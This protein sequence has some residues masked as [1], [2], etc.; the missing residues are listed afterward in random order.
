MKKIVIA[1]AL[2]L[3][4]VVVSVSFAED[5]FGEKKTYIVEKGDKPL[6]IIVSL[7]IISRTTP[8]KIKE[9]NP[10]LGLHNISIGQKIE[11]YVK[12]EDEKNGTVPN[13][14]LYGLAIILVCLMVVS[15][16]LIK[17][18]FSTQGQ[19]TSFPL[20]INGEG[21]IYTPEKIKNRYISLFRRL[22]YKTSEDA[23]KSSKKILQNLLSVR[24]KEISA[25]RLRPKK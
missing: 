25:G 18:I 3:S 15:L 13:D 9:W 2:I 1:L 22:E 23:F 21:Y 6:D 8:D 16:F 5:S 19:R 14:I 7:A 17:K 10:G 20:I 12:N 4:L 24:N 11:Y